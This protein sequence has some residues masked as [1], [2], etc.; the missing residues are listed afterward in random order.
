M[1]NNRPPAVQK[2]VGHDNDERRVAYRGTLSQT[3]K[4]QPTNFPRRNETTRP[5]LNLKIYAASVVRNETSFQWSEPGHARKLV[6][7]RQG[8]PR[9]NTVGIQWR[10]I[11]VVPSFIVSS[12]QKG[13]SLSFSSPI[14]VFLRAGARAKRN[15]TKRNET[16]R[17]RVIAR[18]RRR[19]RGPTPT[20]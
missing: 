11:N 2:R 17:Y 12:P 20:T 4:I 3:E 19:K 8:G 16:K 6:F 9:R 15:E 18:K 1:R 10:M 14:S 7:L 13:G 5:R